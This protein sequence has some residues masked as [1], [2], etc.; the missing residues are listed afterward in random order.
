MM[1][2]PWLA[3]PLLIA[4]CAGNGTGPGAGTLPYRTK[5]TDV[6]GASVPAGVPGVIYVQDFDVDVAEQPPEQREGPV[7][8]V[9]GAMRGET[10]DSAAKAHQLVSL[11]SQSIVDDL[12]DKGLH[13]QRLFPGD[14]PPRTGWL[15]RGVVTE[16]DEGNQLR[17]AVVGFG[18][19]E[20]ELQLYVNLI[21]LAK[22]RDKPFYGFAA[23]NNSGKMPGAA[24]V[25][26][27][28]YA[29]AAKFVMSRHADEREVRNTAA[30]IAE[31]VSEELRSAAPP[32]RKTP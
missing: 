17:K 2:R 27:N 12:D 16:L 14:A 22:D 11:M 25:K 1:R 28:P 13:A 19:G 15:V 30:T 3:L 6:E 26:M 7:R 23:S 5:V 4:A 24:V 8:S 9:L 32:S 18:A 31:R 10:Q 29:A 21:D 20:S